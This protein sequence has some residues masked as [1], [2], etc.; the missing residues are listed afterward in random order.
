MG[1]TVTMYRKYPNR[2]VKTYQL[3]GDEQG[4]ISAVIKKE[5]DKP[6]SFTFSID[7]T[8]TAYSEI[9]LFSTYLDVTYS[10]TCVFYGRAIEVSVGYDRVKKVTCEGCMAFLD[11]TLTPTISISDLSGWQSLVSRYNT[12]VSLEGDRKTLT[13]VF[14]SNITYTAYSNTNKGPYLE[15]FRDAFINRKAVSNAK[16]FH[17]VEQGKTIYVTCSVESTTQTQPVKWDINLIN[18]TENKNAVGIYR[19]YTFY[20]YSSAGLQWSYQVTNPAWE[21]EFGE[22]NIAR[23]VTMKDTIGS[24]DELI[25]YSDKY[26]A[27]LES[28]IYKYDAQAID[29]GITGEYPFFNMSKGV[30]VTLKNGDTAK[31]LP[32]NSATYDILNPSNDRISLGGKTKGISEQIKELQ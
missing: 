6:S 21:E 28:E 10:S 5:L 24:R 9:A 11:D 7:P 27:D 18:Y 20:G 12:S 14:D 32:I 8:H 1:Y 16:V 3:I 23:S 15:A 31:I 19:Q 13:F 30:S 22:Q 25:D 2:T 29:M 17:L 26:M 4:L